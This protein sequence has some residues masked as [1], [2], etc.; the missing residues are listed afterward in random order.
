MLRRYPGLNLT[1]SENSIRGKDSRNDS[2]VSIEKRF[3]SSNA[4]SSPPRSFLLSTFLDWYRRFDAIAL[5]NPIQLK[6]SSVND[7]KATPPTIGTR[8]PS[9]SSEGVS[10]RKKAERRTV[11]KGS[12]ALMVWVKET[13]TLPRLMLVNTVPSMCPA[14]SGAILASCEMEILG[15]G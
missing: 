10:P 12:D 3:M 8:E 2:I 1:P 15:A 7:A 5:Q 9:T 14:A 13:A 11:K 4:S 6:E